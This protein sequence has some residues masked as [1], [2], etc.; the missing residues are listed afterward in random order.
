MCFCP[1]IWNVSVC[2]DLPITEIIVFCVPNYLL[3]DSRG[4]NHFWIYVQGEIWLFFCGTFYR[5][6]D[7]L[8]VGTIRI[9]GTLEYVTW[10]KLETAHSC[11]IIFCNSKEDCLCFSWYDIEK[12]RPLVFSFFLFAIFSLKHDHIGN[13]HLLKYVL[14]VPQKSITKKQPN[15]KNSNSH[16]I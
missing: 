14:A 9:F 2:V 8:F 6:V 1:E 16:K 5:K 3:P 7:F 4:W 11:K 10:T 15:L 12:F 13:W